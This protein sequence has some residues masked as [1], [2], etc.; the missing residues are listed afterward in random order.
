MCTLATGDIM[1][2][3]DTTQSLAIYQSML[4]VQL[5]YDCVFNMN[6]NSAPKSVINCNPQAQTSPGP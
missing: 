6:I 2:L 1:T 5:Y 3:R 4:E